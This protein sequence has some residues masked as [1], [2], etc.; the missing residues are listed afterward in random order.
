MGRALG[1]AGPALVSTVDDC[2]APSRRI[3]VRRLATVAAGI[4]A[5]AAV[6]C[7]GLWSIWLHRPLSRLHAVVPGKIYISAMPTYAGLREAQ[8]RLGFRTIINLFPERTSQRSPRLDEE[9]RFVEEYGIR[10]VENPEDDTKG[11]ETLMRNLAIA[12]DPSAQPVLVHCHGC[13][14]RSPS[15]MGIYRFVHQGWSLREV[16]REIEA[17]RGWRPKSSV[18]LLYD[19]YLRRIAPERYA[20]DTTGRELARNVAGI[21]NPFLVANEGERS[22]RESRD[23]VGTATRGERADAPE[24]AGPRR[25]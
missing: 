23:G 18:T 7:V 22:N 10:Y 5:G 3:G 15:W 11:Y 14:D 13:M 2:P 9:R 24:M 19:Y 16:M 8:K 6:I 1:D 4:G 25:R 20:A 21:T 12:N 17:H